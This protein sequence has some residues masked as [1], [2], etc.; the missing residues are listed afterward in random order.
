M[1]TFQEPSAPSLEY[2]GGDVSEHLVAAVLRDTRESALDDDDD[3]DA[4]DH[5]ITN[6]SIIPAKIDSARAR[7]YNNNNHSSGGGSGAARGGGKGA[8]RGDYVA[9]TA[10]YGSGMCAAATLG[11]PAFLQEK[12]A[13]VGGDAAAMAKAAAAVKIL[14]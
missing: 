2:T 7:N 1:H 6:A 8:Q 4:A 14:S 10:G 5:V 9:E 12:Q 11:M 13:L 3:E